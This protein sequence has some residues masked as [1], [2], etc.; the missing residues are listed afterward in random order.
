GT[1]IGLLGFVTFFGG[2]ILWL[3]AE[4]AHLPATDAVAVVPHSVLV[5]TGATFLV[6][7]VLIALLSVL[8]IF[9]VHLSFAVLRRAVRR[10]EFTEGK[11][12]RTESERLAEEGQAA[13]REAAPDREFAG[14]MANAADLAEKVGDGDGARAH[15]LA[16]ASAASVRAAQKESEARDKLVTAAAKKTESDR[17]MAA[18]NAAFGRSELVLEYVLGGLVLL[19]LPTVCSGA[20]FHLSFWR[21][22]ALV[23][24]A[25]GVVA[26]SIAVYLS[27]EKF[28]WFGITAFVTVGIYIGF[29]SYFA[30]VD[31]P[32]IEPAAALRTG[33]APA[34]GMYIAETS[35]N[36]YL[37]TFPRQGVPSRLI[38]IPRE[39]VTDLTIGPLL[40][41]ADAQ[42]RAL[43]LVVHECEI[44]TAT[45]QNGTEPESWEHACS[46][47]QIKAV[48]NSL[49]GE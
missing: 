25:I 2:A 7:A 8:C 10:A 40:D 34:V 15:L 23:G 45:P 38:V 1:G 39:Q 42:T 46:G 30:T 44:R 48:R 19:V 37:G 14:G 31:N 22:V 33:R 29:A 17:K 32:K 28:I 27:T 49:E 18:A 26:V 21:V 20:V 47:K 11:E 41:P 9:A 12:L 3:R 24:V 5:A 4:Q 16:D 43:A 35:S 36:L 13:I 6:P